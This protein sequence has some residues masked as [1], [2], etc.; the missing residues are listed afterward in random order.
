MECPDGGTQNGTYNAIILERVE[1]SQ[2]V[3]SYN[4]VSREYVKTPFGQNRLIIT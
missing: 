2:V 3:R 4:D 1:R